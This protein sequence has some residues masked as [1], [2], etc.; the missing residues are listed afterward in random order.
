ME[1]SRRK[2]IQGAAVIGGATALAGLTG[3]NTKQNAKNTDTTKASASY[4]ITSTRDCDILIVGAGMSG[5][6]AAVQAG[7]NGNKV[8]LTESAAKTGGNGAGVEGLFA[9]N[10]KPQQKLGIHINPGQVLFSELEWAQWRPNGL[11]W[12]DMIKNSADNYDWLVTQG[13]QFSGIVDG[14]TDG[15]ELS[16]FHWFS[17]GADGRF[18]GNGQVGYVPFMTDRAAKLGVDTMLSTKVV[19]LIQENGV[20]KGA[21]ALDAQ[22]KYMQINAAAVILATG[23]FASNQELLQR[24]GYTVMD[25]IIPIGAP[26]HDGDGYRMAMTAGA[27][28]VLA[29]ACY[30]DG[31]TINHGRGGLSGPELLQG[32][33]LAIGFGGPFL[34]VNENCERFVGEAPCGKTIL[35]AG[36][37][38]LQQKYTY[39]I[40]GQ[41]I[42]DGFDD[43]AKTQLAELVKACPL[44]NIY[45][46]DTV[47]DLAKSVNL[48]PEALN[49]TFDRYQKLCSESL[50]EDFAKPSEM[51]IPFTAPYYILRMDPWIQVAI[52]GIHTNRKFEACD[53]KNMPI[54]GLYAAGVDGTELWR[55]VYTINIPGTCN[56]NNINSG[57]YAAINAAKYI[58]G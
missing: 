30:L 45:K 57:R 40:F 44:D 10:S 43:T 56:A 49:A 31:L 42:A 41:N 36:V 4:D 16:T 28:D 51:M 14:Y 32:L 38:S 34:W 6:A 23:G 13:A 8:I 15:A 17:G 20:I 37:P 12:M 39:F 47:N 53:E 26:G 48:D 52:G 1:L 46:K 54:P 55:C 2:F 25:N 18:G 7:E 3:C 33:P 19:D 22:G 9:V 21:Y 29:D 58:K 5:L 11:L 24:R 27:K 35:S 50:D